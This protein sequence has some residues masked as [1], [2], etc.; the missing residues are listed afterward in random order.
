ME[1]EELQHQILS[2]LRKKERRAAE[3]VRRDRL[4]STGSEGSVGGPTE[5]APSKSRR[6]TPPVLFTTEGSVASGGED[7]KRKKLDK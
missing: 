4:A 3:K 1:D 6:K 5:P 2:V 7:K